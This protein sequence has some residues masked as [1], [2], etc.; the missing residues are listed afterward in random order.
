MS[1]KFSIVIPVYNRETLILEALDSVKNQS[2]RPLELVVVDDGS[3]DRTGEVVRN[4]ALLNDD[5]DEFTV[6]YVS[7]ANAG[8]GAARNRGI[9]EIE[10]EYVQYLDSDDRLHPE[11]LAR[12][13]AMFDETGAEFIQTGFEGFCADCGEVIET[14]LGK[15]GE[16]QFDLALRGRF[17][18]NTLRCA[19]RRNLVQRSPKWDEEMKCFE[20]YKYV[21]GL[22]ARSEKSIAIADVLASARRGGG[23]RVSDRLRT[24]EGRGYRIR[25]EEELAKGIQLRSDVREDGVAQFASRIYALGFRSAASGWPDL[26]RRC[27]RLADGLDAILDS[28][29]R[30]RRRVFRSGPIISR[31]YLKMGSWKPRPVG[32]NSSA[33]EHQCH[34]G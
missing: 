26:A 32:R 22:L 19:M 17:W 16:D 1:C 12:V 15:P 33:N 9:S 5:G 28:L 24:R 29:G 7:Q 11:R 30:R 8:P 2:Y 23:P 10:G 27:G 34:G 21:M 3:T 20:D 25:A 14:R 6:H 18:A 31:L 4:W 13:A